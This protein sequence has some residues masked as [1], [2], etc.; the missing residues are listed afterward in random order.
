MIPNINTLRA[1][2]KAESVEP[3]CE[4]VRSVEAAEARC[5]YRASIAQPSTANAYWEAACVL[6]GIV[7]EHWKTCPTC[8][9]ED[10]SLRAAAVR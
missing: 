5:R 10:A 6:K 2:N 1:A 8:Q 9:E 3:S 4:F 7:L